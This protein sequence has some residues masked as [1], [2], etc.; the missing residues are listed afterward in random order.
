MKRILKILFFGFLVW[1]ILFIIGFL[2]FP[3]HQ[4]QILLFKTIMVVTGALVGMSMLV[5][6]YRKVESNFVSEGILVGV[7]WL[8]VNIVLD[9]IVLVG[10]F[11]NP[12]SEY[13]IGTGLRYLNIPVMSIGVGLILKGRI[14]NG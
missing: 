3:L 10:L 1:L 11:Q 9:L 8:T 2:I 4:T 13:F 12:V 5:F 14:V 6:Y 7:I